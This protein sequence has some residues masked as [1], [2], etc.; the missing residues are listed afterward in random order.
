[1]KMGQKEDPNQFILRV[2]LRRKQYGF[3]KDTCFLIF[4]QQLPIEYCAKL[5]EVKDIIATFDEAGV[6]FE[7]DWEALVRRAERF[8]KGNRL[9]P[10][11]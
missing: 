1:M 2:E 6:D 9:A 4:K 10:H 3:D 11:S 5:D 7:L 8:V